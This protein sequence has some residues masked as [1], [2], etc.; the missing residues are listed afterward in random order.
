MRFCT[1][2]CSYLVKNDLYDLTWDHI[3]I[4]IIYQD[5]FVSIPVELD[6]LWDLQDIMELS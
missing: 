6:P 2:S 5:L 1:S 3:Q 4:E